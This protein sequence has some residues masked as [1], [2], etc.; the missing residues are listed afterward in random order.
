MAAATVTSKWQITFPASVRSELGLE[1]GSRV[2][3]V[4]LDHGQFSIV[5]MNKDVQTLKGM[6]SKPADPVSIEQMNAA[7]AAHGAATK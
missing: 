6:L 3:F 4:K 5:A 1:K 2:E 7:V